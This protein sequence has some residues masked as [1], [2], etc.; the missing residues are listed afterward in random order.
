MSGYPHGVAQAT[1][2]DPLRVLEEIKRQSLEALGGL[3]GTLY[4]PV[5]DAL[6][7]AALKSD[8]KVNHYEEQAA[9]WVLRQHQATHVM[10]F[11]QQV[12]QSFDDFRALRIRSGG[13]VTL[14]LVDEQQLE[15]E[16]ASGRLNEALVAR[17]AR[18]LDTLQ[19]RLQT[20]ADAMRVPMGAN[21]I[22]PE[23]LVAAFSQTLLDAQVPDTLRG[24]LFRFYE[25]D[26]IRVLGELYARINTL[27]A[28]SGYGGAAPAPRPP[29][30]DLRRFQDDV[31]VP[32]PH[33]GGF[34]GTHDGF[35]GQHSPGPVSAAGAGNFGRT[36][37]TPMSQQDIAAMASELSQLR[38]QLH[39]WRDS[40]PRA[41]SHG[42][43]GSGF[44]RSVGQRREMRVDEILSVASLLQAEP[45]D[46]FARA[47][48]VSGRLG[49]TIRDHL[50]DG[51]RRL[52]LN[53][54]QACFSAEEE[55]AI[56]LVALLF[57]SLFRHNALQDRARRLYA[58]LVLPYVKVAL[59]D[60]AVFVKRE[61]PARRLLD[62][63]TEAC[64]G[65]DGETPQDRE[66]LD[67][68]TEISQR[69]VAEY[70]EDLAVF[71]LAHA[72]LDA[73]LAQQRRRFEL[74][75][76]RAAKA[77][78][79]RERLG[80]ARSQA[81]NA[82]H[83]RTGETTLTQAVA[84]FL[85]MPWRHHVVQTL[86][87][88]NVDQRRHAEAIALGDALVMADRLAQQN[89]GRELADQLL[90]LQ[91]AIIECLASSGLDDSAA[92]HGLA[93]LVR[94][95]V[96]PDTSRRVRPAAPLSVQEDDTGEAER[97]LWLAG[98]TDTVRHDPL[99]AERMRALEVGDW[100]RL[101]D[102]DGES[103]AAKVAWVSPLTSRFLLVNR[104]GLRVLAASAEELAALAT[105][106]RLTIGAERTAF[107]E[108]MR[109]VRR[110]LD[111]GT[112]TR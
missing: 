83:E 99:L 101:V 48:A 110:H 109:Q 67:R 7:L 16:L 104:R 82:L 89:R 18:P 40:V 61:H 80:A 37:S 55:D 13:D 5:E 15:Y 72:E 97:R 71:E 105:S 93:G 81:E 74:Q 17:F 92:Q 44:D 22:G 75:E 26:L 32:T 2:T 77:T 65:N 62:A 107:D 79:G 3:P 34:G 36:L 108:A 91:P 76:Q 45:P 63:I 20:L 38:S 10:R 30:E 54:D 11:R 69:I 100:V 27:L 53:P 68:A 96:D 50:Q 66:L 56:D 73:L 49:E 19:S 8:G 6:K 35:G 42:M 94:A 90:A 24:R 47:L 43:P 1:R 88:D 52:G 70:N 14:R 87:R 98:G 58:R 9:L 51:A 112:G 4:G 28:T 86:L 25:T 64:E 41:D 102:A 46:A 106:G 57:D 31:L 78:Y 84:D 95:L 29:Q 21:P 12:A 60:N 39:A 59:T 103:A 33:M 23:R 85:A 111:R